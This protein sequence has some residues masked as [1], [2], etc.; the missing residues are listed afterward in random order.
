MGAP[1]T[2]NSTEGQHSSQALVFIWDT[3]STFVCVEE[4]TAVKRRQSV[5]ISSRFNVSLFL[6]LQSVQR[7]GLKPLTHSFK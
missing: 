4:G 3:T 7:A 1:A 6:F 2:T 5:A